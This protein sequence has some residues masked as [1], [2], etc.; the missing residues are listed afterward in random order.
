M[1]EDLLLLFSPSK[2]R[3]GSHLRCSLDGHLVWNEWKDDHCGCVPNQ[4]D[5]GSCAGVNV[6]AADL[7]NTADSL[8]LLL[9]FPL[10]L[11]LISL[12]ENPRPFVKL[13]GIRQVIVSV[14]RRN[15]HGE[16]NHSGR[17]MLDGVVKLVLTMGLHQQGRRRP[18]PSFLAT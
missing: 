6:G 17:A 16:L 9:P 3:V 11:P 10:R 18:D 2:Y 8:L 7:Q 4:G 1:R 15:V 5:I 13:L 14:E 12:L